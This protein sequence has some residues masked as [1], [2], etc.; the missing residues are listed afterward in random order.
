MGDAGTAPGPATPPPLPVDPVRA[1]E[2]ASCAGAV[3][4]AVTLLNLP[5]TLVHCLGCGRLLW[6][7]KSRKRRRGRECAEKAGI[8]D[9]P[10]PRIARRD[11]GDCEGQTDLLKETT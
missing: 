11:R 2:G 4:D 7:P 1:Y 3:R 8:I 5:I 6:D 10:S 9:P